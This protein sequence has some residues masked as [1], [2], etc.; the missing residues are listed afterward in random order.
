LRSF[1]IKNLRKNY[2][3][4]FHT[5]KRKKKEEEKQQSFSQGIKQQCK[6]KMSTPK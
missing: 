1:P 6:K 2:L 3:H 4:K 5:K